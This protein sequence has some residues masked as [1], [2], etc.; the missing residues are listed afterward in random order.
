M[1]EFFG[2][3]FSKITSA[4]KSK[5][6]DENIKNFQGKVDII[7]NDLLLPYLKPETNVAPNDRFRE[8]INLLDP[9]KCNKIAMT[10]SSNL[11]KNY[12]KLQ[13]EQFSN[14]ILIGKEQKECADDSCSDNDVKDM[15][16]K[17]GEI[18]KRDMCNSVAV[19]YVKI[20]NLIA[21]VLTAVN[22]TDNICLNRLRN[23]L[24]VINEDEKSGMSSIC[25]T[26]NT[27]VKNS[28]IQEPGFKELLTLY[29]Y[30]I[31][32]DTETEQEKEN[33]RSQYKFLVQTFSN[34][35]IFANPEM[36]K[37]NE[38]T[39]TKLNNKINNEVT[40]NNEITNTN[41]TNNNKTNN[42][43][44][45]NDKPNTDKPNNTKPNNTKPNNT[46]PNTKPNNKSN[47]SIENK[48]EYLEEHQEEK[49][50]EY[51][52]KLQ[53]Q[54]NNLSSIK[55]NLTSF[56]LKDNEK[57]NNISN[58]IQ[59][60]TNSIAQMHTQ[61]TDLVNTTAAMELDNN[62]DAA[63]AAAIDDADADAAA[64]AIADADAIDDADAAAAAAA[65]ADADAAAADASMELSNTADAAMSQQV[66]TTNT[67]AAMPQQVNTTNT[68]NAMPQQVNTTNTTNATAVPLP[69][70]V[71]TTNATTV[72]LPQQ[73][74]TTNATAVPLPQQA[75]T[76]NAAAATELINN[77]SITNKP[78][79]ANTIKS[80][81][82]NSTKLSLGNN[83]KQKGGN[84]KNKN[85]KKSNKSNNNNN[86]NNNNNNI[87]LNN[88]NNNN[89]NNLNNPELKENGETNQEIP[90][91]TEKLNQKH[92]KA[93]QPV[94][95]ENTNYINNT[96]ANNT[97]A[98]NT[99]ANNTAVN[100]TAVNNTAVNNTSIPNNLANDNVL[101]N[102]ETQ[103]LNNN[104]KKSMIVKFIDFV[105]LYNN[106]D[107]IDDTLF[108]IVKTSFKT[109]DKF[110][111]TIP[112][113]L[114]L[115]INKD[116]MEEFCVEKINND[117][118]IPI[119]LD[120]PRLADYIKIYKDMKD[121]YI[122][123]CEYLLNLIEK[124]ILVKLPVDDSDENPRFT[125]QNIGYAELV[126]TETDIRNKLV[127]MYSGCHE[128][129]QKGIV[130]LY[131]ALK[132]PAE[133]AA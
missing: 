24:V 122:D 22:P 76:T 49:F 88:L 8:M 98:N 68:T 81:A 6:L 116:E 33:V 133:V 132:Q 91:E 130:A 114:P 4:F 27:V 85:N 53:S 105:K 113:E 71:N 115:Y 89:L 34:M 129:Y 78:N 82:T 19:H 26:T 32:Q 119:K 40:N 120:D 102:G 62:T 110:D 83:K 41:K 14:S 46:K 60:L 58:K 16:N 51:N 15:T 94:T 106:I 43:K 42:N 118:M 66:N 87:N 18:S 17:T 96:V 28:I 121:T 47:T 97:V 54:S 31:I 77:T 23:L 1:A 20:M 126:T 9:K 79:N 74:N 29:Y 131:T 69:Q 100:N 117:S 30:N 111:S 93:K 36:N 59:K 45:N 50:K 128:Q 63:A 90:I 35:V 12:T 13:I 39:N 65:I 75:N 21:A 5:D 84:K 101:N 124:K 80:N 37:N 95:I 3:L 52:N 55:N 86:I 70:Q 73:V 7:V 44:T 107:K 2:N 125:I 25:D 56:K 127:A 109:Y 99:V 108:E 57:L 123:N 10:L 64:A 11:E 72:P 67:T 112:T 38:V 103:A 104:S 61:N 92:E 48:L